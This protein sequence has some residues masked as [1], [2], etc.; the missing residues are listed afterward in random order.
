MFYF[1]LYDE[2]RTA[3]DTLVLRFSGSLPPQCFEKMATSANMR[4]TRS[5]MTRFLMF[6]TGYIIVCASFVSSTRTVL[7]GFAL[8]PD[9]VLIMF[10]FAIGSV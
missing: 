9:G 10:L 3:R 1:V 6:P 4:L 2:L 8:R 7:F 5:L